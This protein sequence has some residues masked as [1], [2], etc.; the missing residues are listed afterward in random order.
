M[1]KKILV[2]SGSPKK[3]GNT[4]A[5]VSWFSEGARSKGAEIEI[6]QTALIQIQ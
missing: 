5:L 2:F 4:A 3:D 1:A 6:V